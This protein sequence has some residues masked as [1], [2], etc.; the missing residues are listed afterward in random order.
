MVH[1]KYDINYFHLYQLLYILNQDK[2][3]KRGHLSIELSS[4]H[5]LSMES[6][7]ADAQIIEGRQK[8]G[9]TSPMPMV[10]HSNRF[11]SQSSVSLETY[12]K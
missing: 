9:R 3:T 10:I 7:V 12:N 8:E 5:N 1:I 11:T 2:S 6:T 4:K